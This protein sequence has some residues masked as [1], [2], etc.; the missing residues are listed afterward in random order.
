MNRIMKPML[1]RITVRRLLLAACIIPLA[2]QPFT[3]SRAVAATT[4]PVLW[5]AGGLSAGTDSAGQAARIATDASGNVAVVSGPS[6]GRDL[7]VTSYTATG[8]LRWR[9][10][11]SPA[12]GTFV[13]D[14][15]VAAPNGDFVAVGHN[16]TSRGQ[17]IAISMVRYASDGTLLWRLGGRSGWRIEHGRGPDRCAGTGR[18]HHRGDGAR[19]PQPSGRL[20]PGRHSRVQLERNPAVGGLLQDGHDLGHGSSQQ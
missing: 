6:G 13:G 3:A 16:V 14:W 10:V 11:V 5:T 9:G 19:R 4:L 15:V 7:A 12:S 2:L 18:R 17:P 1:K 20:Y 8:S